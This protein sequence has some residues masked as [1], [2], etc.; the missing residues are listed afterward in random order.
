MKTIILAGGC[1]WCVEHDLKNLKGV[2]TVVSGYSGDTQHKADYGMVAAH[3]TK[4]REVV[5][6]TYSKPA[7]MRSVVQWYLDHIDPTDGQGQFFDRGYQYEPVIYY[8]DENEKNLIQEI[9][10]ELDDSK[11]YEKPIA[12]KIEPE[13]E[14]FEAEQYHQNYSKENPDAY[15]SYAAG[16]GRKAHTEKICAIRSNK[17][18]KWKYE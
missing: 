1:F 7:T 13:Q 12:V 18:M 17:N 2:E 16:S 14:F 5:K 4:H 6:V 8:K 10:K 11:L 3:L 9:L 15:E